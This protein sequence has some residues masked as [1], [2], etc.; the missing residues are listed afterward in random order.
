MP[1]KRLINGKK[2]KKKHQNKRRIKL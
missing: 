2:N 1:A